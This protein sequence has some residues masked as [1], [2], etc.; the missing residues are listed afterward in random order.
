MHQQDL[1]F[2][3]PNLQC[4]QDLQFHSSILTSFLCAASVRCLACKRAIPKNE[5][6][7][8]EGREPGLCESCK[9][10]DGRLA[11]VYLGALSELNSAS[12]RRHAALATCMRCHSG[13]LMGALECENGECSVLFSRLSASHRLSIVQHNLARL[14]W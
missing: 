7:G 5:L 6:V 8:K 9:Q 3:C 14:D 12:H 4:D 10:E 11:A 2:S 1:P 13:N